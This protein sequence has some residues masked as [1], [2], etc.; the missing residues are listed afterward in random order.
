MSFFPS[1]GEPSAL[2]HNAPS[3]RPDSSQESGEPPSNWYVDGYHGGHLY[4][5]PVGSWRDMVGA[6]RRHPNWA[7]V[8][9][10][11]PESW[12]EG[13]LEDPRAMAELRSLMM[14]HPDR[15]EL[16]NHAFGHPYHWSIDAEWS[17]RHFLQG[18]AL[19]R[20]LFPEIDWE[21]WAPQEPMWTSCM[22]GI[23]LEMGYRA[24][25]L[26]SPGTAFAGLA[27]G[28]DALLLEWVGPDGSRIPAVPRYACE[29][30]CRTWETEAR[31]LKRA[32]VEKCRDRGI[33]QPVGTGLQDI[34]WRGKP[35]LPF[36]DSDLQ[37]GDFRYSTWSTYLDALM[38]QTPNP[39]R[40]EL[41]DFRVGLP[42]GDAR[43]D[44]VA[45]VTR[46]AEWRLQMVERTEVICADPQEERL[47]LREWEQD[48][49]R[50][51]HHDNWICARWRHGEQNFCTKTELDTWSLRSKGTNLLR[52]LQRTWNRMQGNEDMVVSLS[53]PLGHTV[54][55]LLRVAVPVD[56]PDQSLVLEDEQ[57]QPIPLQVERPRTDSDT[58][59]EFNNHHLV[60]LAEVDLPACGIRSWRLRPG[61]PPETTGLEVRASEAKWVI[62][63]ERLGRVVLNADLGG[64][65]SSWV[66]AGETVDRVP[67]GTA[68]GSFRGCINVHA[69]DS[70]AEK[71]TLE[72]LEAGP[73]SVRV[74]STVQH[75]DFVLQTEWG[76][77]SR[78]PKVDVQVTLTPRA[79]PGEL[80][81]PSQILPGAAGIQTHA[82]LRIGR[83]SGETDVRRL[84]AE[85]PSW[86][87]QTQK[88]RMV[89]PMRGPASRCFRE[90]PGD[91]G[92]AR[93]LEEGIQR[94]EELQSETCTRWVD[95][96]QSEQQGVA[97]FTDRHSAFV[98]I[99][100]EEPAVVMAWAG[101]PHP[102]LEPVTR[103]FAIL[104]HSGDWLD[105]GL[106]NAAR[107]WEAGL[108]TEAQIHQGVAASASVVELDHPDWELTCCRR[109]P[110]GVELRIYNS[111]TKP[112]SGTITFVRQPEAVWVCSPCGKRRENVDAQFD[113][114]TGRLPLELTSHGWITLRVSGLN[115]M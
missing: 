105:A 27:A 85:E 39:R 114:D 56:D 50:A 91:V 98:H 6:I 20:D 11:E 83:P 84:F 101:A 13:L 79:W 19:F 49:L 104:P 51:Q 36:K 74:R 46:Q 59:H 72:V 73:C 15:F 109:C 75:P 90:G 76:F 25:V 103:R 108:H 68:W 34:G 44:R 58:S 2:H 8:F 17:F 65:V 95:F 3:S 89:M 57:G 112:T 64:A 92:E 86:F 4:G 81:D 66:P 35:A 24:A 96:T 7:L 99:Q 33:S 31:Y 69:F 9:D 41:D 100:D 53:N 29:D 5:V 61:L 14:E 38:E 111:S 12:S 87:D 37:E 28:E 113:P 78:S 40:L 47:D 67:E 1:S 16:V 26:K 55:R 106:W 60:L 70:A 63:G 45:Q 48:V 23:L 77:C 94:W 10:L 21:V 82:G 30:T 80:T 22:P 54:Q 97:C 62:R 102:L 18:E 110:E 115:Q 52:E 71:A 32:F 88:L 107:E 42:W 93:L 43:L